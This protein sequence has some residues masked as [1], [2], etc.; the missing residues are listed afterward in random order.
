MINNTSTQIKNNDLKQSQRRR[1]L[2]IFACS[3]VS[4]LSFPGIAT[5]AIQ[6]DRQPRQLAFDHTHTGEKLSIT[7]YE[8]GKYLMD[9]LQE[10]NTL[11]RDHRTGE[12]QVI[13]PALLNQL[14]N[15]RSKLGVNKPFHII[16]GY[17]SPFTNAQLQKRSSGVAKKSLHMLGKAIDVRIEGVDSLRLRNTAI[18][19]RQGG[20]GYYQ[21]SNFVHLDTG[22]VRSW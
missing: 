4:A 6:R 1:F 18:A 12:I 21:R 17:R 13:D 14:H 16:S 19:M 8:N 11:L 10:I 9:A 5:A 7:Y 15:L 3:S 2:K 20:V 22:R